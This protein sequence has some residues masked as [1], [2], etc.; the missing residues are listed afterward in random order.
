VNVSNNLLLESIERIMNY[1]V[2]MI[3][4]EYNKEL[5]VITSIGLFINITGK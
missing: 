1:K 3:K 2:G 5:V 4:N